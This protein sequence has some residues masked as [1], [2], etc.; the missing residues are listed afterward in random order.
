MTKVCVPTEKWIFFEIAVPNQWKRSLLGATIFCRLPNCWPSECQ[1][2]NCQNSNCQNSNC[3]NSNCQNLQIS[4]S[5]I[6]WSNPLPGELSGRGSNRVD[7]FPHFDNSEAEIRTRGILTGTVRSKASKMFFA[8]KSLSAIIPRW[9]RATNDY[10]QDLH[11]ICKRK[12]WMDF[13]LH[14]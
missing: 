4:Y 9:S 12:S 5:T 8:E 7:N 2:S 6:S 10:F 1:N 13:C 3:Q 14:F 11:K